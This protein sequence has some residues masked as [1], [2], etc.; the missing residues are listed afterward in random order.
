M[1]GDLDSLQA[2]PLRTFLATDAQTDQRASEFRTCLPC[3][4]HAAAKFGVGLVQRVD[5]R[6]NACCLES[7]ETDAG[8]EEQGL[9]TRGTSARP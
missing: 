1:F 2:P 6:E 9:Y 3:C 4:R 8:F 5:D 7:C